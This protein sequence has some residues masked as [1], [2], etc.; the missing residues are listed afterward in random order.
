MSAKPGFA[1][2]LAMTG[3]LG[4]CGANEG[5]HGHAHGEGTHTHD[6]PD[7]QALYGD[8]AARAGDAAAGREHP[9]GDETHTHGGPDGGHGEDEAGEPDHD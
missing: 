2:L 4:A 6:A 7:T 1:V 3:A 5:D 8:E 9:H